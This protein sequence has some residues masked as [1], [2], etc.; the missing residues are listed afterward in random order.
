[1]LVTFVLDTSASMNQSTSSG[2]TLLDYA[3]S[4]VERF[5]KR[6]RDPSRRYQHHFMLL[7]CGRDGR[8][9]GGSKSADSTYNG[10]VRVGWDQSTNK[11]AFLRELKNLRATDL[12]DVGAALKQAFELMNQIRLQFNWDSYALGRAPWNTNVSV[13]VL[14]TDA[15]T[16][17]SADG[18]IQDALTIAPSNTVGAD[19][20]FEPYRWDQRL[21]TVALKLSATMNGVKGQP[22]V[23]ADLMALS[24][25]TGGML[26]MPTSKPAVEQSIDQIIL[27]LK[28]GAVVKFKCEAM[29]GE[30][31][32]PVARNIIA[33]FHS[34]KE[35]CWPVAE[36][37][38]LDRNTV[39]LPTREAHPTLVYSRTVENAIEAATSHMLLDTLKFPADT[40]VLETSISPTPSRG[41]RWLVYVQG[42]KG[43]GRLGDP[44]GMLRA[45]SSTPGIP[46]FNPVL[47]LLPYNFPKLFSLLVEV[48]RVYQASGQNI[49]SASGT[50]MFQAK[51]MPSSWR[52]SF[53]AYLS[54]CPL[55]YYAPLKK[56][57]RK[58]N[59]HDMVPEVQ[60]S[61]RSYQISS[62][63][64]RLREQAIA[65]SDSINKLFS[66]A[67]RNDTSSSARSSGIP[68][69]SPSASPI[70]NRDATGANQTDATLDAIA[71][72]SLQELRAAHQKSKALF[73]EKSSKHQLQISLPRVTAPK[74]DAVPLKLTPSWRAVEEDEKHR[75]P[76]DVMSDYESRLIKK[77][78]LRNP[79]AEAEPDEDTPSGLRRRQ[80]SFNLGNPYKKSSSKSN[81]YQNEAADEA[82]ALGGQSPKRQRTRKR[83]SQLK[84][85]KKH[86]KRSHRMHGSP[87]FKSSPGSPSHS[88]T[89]PVSST[90]STIPSPGRSD[91]GDSVMTDSSVGSNYSVKAEAAQMLGIPLHDGDFVED[92]KNASFVR[93]V[94]GVLAENWESWSTIIRLIKA[95]STTQQEKE[96]VVSGLRSMKGSSTAVKTYIEQAIYYSQQ[97]RQKALEQQLK[98]LL[99]EVTKAA[100]D[101]TEDC[102]PDVPKKSTSSDIEGLYDEQAQFKEDVEEDTGAV[103]QRPELAKQLPIKAVGLPLDDTTGVAGSWS[104]CMVTAFDVSLGRF[105]V[106][107]SAGKRVGSPV[108]HRGLL[109]LEKDDCEAFV[110]RIQRA[111]QRREQAEAV[112]RQSLY[113]ESMPISSDT[114]LDSQTISNILQLTLSSSSVPTDIGTS[115]L[116]EEVNADY[117]Y[118]M[119]KLI[120]ETNVDDIQSEFSDLKLPKVPAPP[121]PPQC[122]IIPVP[123]YDYNRRFLDIAT[124]KFVNLS[125][126]VN[127]LLDVRRSC[128][129]VGTQKLLLEQQ[130]T[131]ISFGGGARPQPKSISLAEFHSLHAQM[132]HTALRFMRDCWT[133]LAAKRIQQHF[134]QAQHPLYNPAEPSRQKYLEMPLRRF[135]HRVNY[136]VEDTLRVLIQQNFEGYAEFVEEMAGYDV[137]DCVRSVASL[138]EH[139][140]NIVERAAQPL[141]KYHLQFD[142]YIPLLNLDVDEY[143]KT[144][145]RVQPEGNAEGEDGEPTPILPPVELNELRRLLAYHRN[146]EETLMET[147]PSRAVNLG[148]FQ[149]DLTNIRFTLAKKH[150]DC[151]ARL[152][153][154]QVAFCFQIA[155]RIMGKFDEINQNLS[156]TPKDIESLTALQEYIT[157]LPAL[158]AP[159]QEEILQ[160]MR[161]NTLIDDFHHYV[162]DEHLRLTWQVQGWPSK[163]LAQSARFKHALEERKSK[164]AKQMES[165]QER[166]E[167]TLAALQDEIETFSR[168]DNLAFVED[169]AHHAMSVQRKLEQAQQDAM[170]FNSRETLFGQEVT[171]YDGLASAKK[172]F[173]PYHQLWSTSYNWIQSR[174]TWIQGSFIDIDAEQVEKLVDTYSTGIQKAYKFF[175][176]NGNEACSKIAE[177]VKEQIS[178]FRPYVPLIVAL[179]NPGMRLRHWEEL[180]KSLGFALEIDESFTLTNIFQLNLLERID[181]IVKVAE[182][183]GKEYQVEQALRTMKAAWETVDLQIIAYRETGTYVIKG[184]DEIQAILDEHVTMTQAMMFSTF[185]GPFEEE[186]IEWN[187]TLQLISEVLE[188]WLAVQRNWL[189]LQPIFESPDINKQLPAEG[190]RFASVDKNWRQTLASAKAKPK[191]VEFCRSQKLLE[192]FRESNHFLELVQ[193]GLSDYLEVKRS[194]FARFYFLSNDELLSILSESKDVKLVQ[195]HLK[196]CFEGIVQVTFEDDLNISAM[197]SAEGEK[198]PFSSMVD[199]KGKNVEHWMMEVEDMMKISIRD[200][201]ERAIANYTQIDR[202]LWIQKWPG[203]CVLNGSQMHWTREMEEAMDADGR[204]GVQKMMTRQLGQLADMVTLVRGNLDN[205]ARITCGALTVIDV[206]A[207][208]VTRKL[209]AQKVESKGDFLWSS[210]LKYYWADKNLWVQAVTSRRPYGYEYLGNS[211][212]LVITPLTDKCYL[213]LMGALQMILGGAPAG[214]AG[215]GKT[216]TTKDLAKALAKQCVVFNCSDGLDY[217]AMGKFFK[218]LASCGAWA[219]FDEFNRI[220]IEV[221]SVVG[222]QVVTLQ[223]GIRRGDTRIIFEG[224]D[225]KLSDQFGVFITMNP[226]YAGRSELPDSLAALFRPVAMMVPD[227]ALIGEIMFFAYGFS[228]ARAL[229]AKMVTTFKLCSEQLSSQFHYDYGMRAVK[230]VITAA[231]NLKRDDPDMDEDVL[232]LRALQDVNLP[233]FLAHDIPLFNG[234]ISDLFP[235]KCRPNLDLGAL[236]SVIKLQ[237]HRLNLQPVPY[238]L[239]K[240]IQLYETIVVRHGLMVVGATGGGK[241]CNIAVLAD[242][243]TELK[244]RGE[245]GFAFEKV[246][247]YQLN[248]KSITMGQL[249]GEFDP[250]THEWQDGILSTLYRAAASDTKPDRKWVIFDGPVDAIWIENMNTVLDDNKKLCLNSGEMLQMSKQMTMMFEVEDLSV[251]SPATVSRTGMVYME[252]S[253]L[254]LG[255]LVDSW[256]EH[257]PKPV[258]QFGHIFMRLF[259]VYLYASVT[260][261][262]SFLGEL[263]PTMDNNLA[264]SL[265]NILDCTLDPFREKPADGTGEP[266]PAS[267]TPNA[268]FQDDI[269]PLFIFALIWSVGASTND[270]GRVRFDSFLRSELVANNCK[271]PLPPTGLVYDYC[272]QL[273]SHKWV[274]WM[275]TVSPYKVPANSSFAEIV[276]PTADSVR[277]NFLLEELMSAGKHVLMVGGTGTGKTVNITRYLQSLPTDVYIPIPISFSAQTSANQTQD[278]LDAKM[279]KRRKGVYGP[280]A[281]K[282]YII[283]VDDLNMPKREKYFAQ[284][285]LEL[286]RQWFDQGGWYD[287]KLL[288]F[289]SIIDILFVASMGPPGGG[290]NPITPRLVRH[291]NVVGY[292]ELGDDSKTIIFSTILGNF[293]GSGF[294]AEIARLTE[295]VVKASIS[296]YN[297]ICR[298]LLPTPAKS[299][300]TFNLRDLAKVFQGVL[301]GDSRRIS[302]TDSLIRLWVHEC[303]RVYEDRMVSTQDHDWF[304]E[305]MRSSV[306]KFFEREYDQVVTNEHLIYGDYLVPGADPKIYEEIVHVDKVLNIMDEYLLDYNAESK[307]PMSLVLF[308]DAV[309]HVSR[310]SRIIRQPMGNALLLGVGGSGRQSLTKL[311]TF[312]AGYKCFQVE[313]VKGYGLTEWRDD[314]KKCLLLAGV[315]DIP[316][317]FLFSDVQVVNETMLEDLNGVLNAGNVPNLYGPEDLDQIVTACRVDCQKRQLPPTKTNIFQQ[318]INRV[319]RNIHLVICMSPLGGLFRDRLRMFP[320]LVNCSTIDWFSEWPAEALNSVASAILSDGNLALGDKLP[321]LVEAFKVV[322]QSVE[323]ASKQFYNTLR[324]Y[325][326]VTPTSYLELLSAF[327]SV[328]VAKR[329]EVNM[330]RSRLQNGVDK[331]SETKAIVATM[332]TELVE[333]QPVL[334]ATQLEVEQM[335]VQIAKDSAEAD[336]TKATVEKEEA[337]ASIKASATKEIADSAQRDLDAALPALESALE[338]LNRLKKADIDE[339]KALKTPPAGVK[340]TM[341]V[342]CILFGQ[343][344]VSKPDPDRPGK[345]INDYWE[346]AQKV[347]LSNA[348]KFLENLLGFDKDNIPDAIITKVTPSMEDPNFTPEAIEKSSK[349]CTAIC[350]WARAMYTYHFVAKAVEPKKQALAQAQKELDET[351]A[352]LRSAQ[353]N[354][355][356]VSDRLAEL[357]QS[358][359]GAV[360]KK[361]ELARKVVQCQVQLQNAERLIGGL[362][363]EE[364]RWKETV[365]Q[366]TLDYSNLTGDVLVSAGTISYLGAFTA[367][368]REQLVASWHEALVKHKVPHSPGC[369]LIRTL[370]DPVKLRAWQIAGLPTDTVST[371]NGIIMGRARRWPLLIDPQGQ[372]NRFIKNLGRDKK[373]CENGMDVV[374]QSDRGFL[375]ALENGLRFGKWVLLENV[376]EELDAALEPVLLQQKFKQG[377]QDMIRLGENVIPYNDSFRFFLTTKLANPH[378]A[379][380][381]CVKVSLLN[382]TITMKGLEEQL[383]GV[384][385]LKELPELAAKKNELV[386]SNAEGKRQLYEIE[387]QILY[388]LSHSEGNILDDTNLIE[389]LASAKETSA[390]VMA[391]MREA[392]ETEREIDARSDG[393]RPVAFRAALLFF[394]IADLALVDP[395]YQYSLTWFTGLFIRGILAAK[396]SAQLETRL[397]NLNDYFTYSVY[398]NICRSLFEKHKLLFSFLLTIKIMQGNNEVDA[399]EWRFL[400]SGIGTGAPVEAENPAARWL[401]AYAWQQICAL[402]SFPAFKGL[403]TEFANHVAVFRAIFDSTDPENQPLPGELL[404]KLDEFQR[405]CILRVLRPDKMM[406]GIQN[407]VCAK[408]GK[409]FIEPPPFDLANTFEDA[410]PTTPLIFVLSQGSDPAKDLHGFA[411]STGME[412][413]LKSI[414]LGQGQGTLAAR[415]IEG[416]T[417]RGEWVLLQNCHLALSWMP[418]LERICEELDPTKLHEDFRLWLTSMPTPAFPASVLQDGVK[419]TK[420]APKGL[421]ANLK[422]TYYKLDEMR[423]GATRKPDVFRKLL[424]GLCFYHAIVCERKRFGALGWNIPYQFNETDLDISVAQLEMFLDTYN[425]VPF[426]V[427][428]VMTSTINYGGRITDDKDMRTSDVILMTFFKEAILQKGYT[429]SKSGI[430]YSLDCDPRN[431][432]DGYVN[433]INLLPINPEPEVF[434]MHENANIT[435]A[436]AETYEAFDLLL[437]LQPRVSSGGGK[438]REEIIADAAQAIASQLPPQYDLEHVQATY[439]V[440]YD[441]SMNTVLAQEVERFNKLLAVMR[442]TLHLVQQGL[443]GLVVMSAELEAMGASLYD[444][445]VP[446]VWEAKAYP[447]L[448]PLGAWV[449]DLLERLT[450]ISNWIAHG[451]PAVFWISGFFFPQG[452]MT[453]T[454]QNHAR[455]YKLP[456]DSLSFQFIMKTESVE[457]LTARP[458]DGCYTYGLFLEGAR[459][460]SEMKALD[461][462]LPRELFAKMP[463]IHLLPQPNREAPQR[464]IYRCPVYKILT[465]TGTLSTTGHSTNFVMWLEIP[466]SKPTIFR[467]SLVSE[468]NA[469]VLFADQEYWIKAGVACFCSLR[470]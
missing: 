375:R 21:F 423:L 278:M 94:Y 195:P 8:S 102:A 230:T 398:K 27:K 226:G 333:L 262:R 119:N 52:E 117:M 393:Y 194:A 225:I 283:Y 424:F 338:C 6:V 145:I 14:L 122:G 432:Y 3:K 144:I 151:F 297:T 466:A 20:T 372:A 408:L 29:E 430:Y 281:G 228:D 335:M 301:M 185:K 146:E 39:A 352:I 176:N 71:S 173:E 242:A 264:Q 284:P 156:S 213:T 140:G 235:G 239:T 178:V 386:L 332:Q 131:E 321:A 38:W 454:I 198:V 422:N 414:A 49:N 391:K 22:T 112:L 435:S 165:E 400:L 469:Q 79:L 259:D 273:S 4:A 337:A 465:R 376:G 163:V 397:T 455:R 174:K 266:Q 392:E 382:F 106:S 245:S 339:V 436:Q 304:R 256:V 147:I 419:M 89:S 285:P 401:E 345:K 66:R 172:T 347:V 191:C 458:V 137:E 342:V 306:K 120:F 431:A 103:D 409:E 109:C 58:Y 328:L 381:V 205:M 329:E 18:L 148:L 371:Q 50:W 319:R 138:K 124:D 132:S 302:E 158:L 348:N 265:M 153:E 37:F 448:K 253:T 217:I 33:P 90:S 199:P 2:M 426:D 45:P 121:P 207:R 186:I 410:S 100:Q 141:L 314:V 220:D 208:D 105:I 384:V 437:S 396:P 324:R 412:S 143:L 399:G 379:P 287:R 111:V 91:S 421:R 222:Q 261:I 317:V 74:D 407:L 370:Q 35:F 274:P 192:R 334:A 82:A 416:A 32:F 355:Q 70:S 461:D 164:F 157:G 404:S 25:A 243:L 175:S 161:D 326:Y 7:S 221:L 425:H 350:M 418:E 263:V 440:C 276:V 358:Y 269:E 252:P 193:K 307:S 77:E 453:G 48:A 26:Y 305:L 429:F 206:H 93:Q 155:T 84:R 445:K 73:F 189:Y 224:S 127:A 439:P 181:D 15:T 288:V 5:V 260:F 282:K 34:G 123:A 202:S 12:S 190:K 9:K 28:A 16:L 210:Q 46:T 69:S 434:G 92:E 107:W 254:G 280:P 452:F 216:E 405:L 271:P 361:E 388:L 359:N 231:G 249:Y 211:F 19:L 171:S 362:G 215:T 57:L 277:N 450:F 344:P 63:L 318:Y 360:A 367:E 309:E 343:K 443:K 433:Y 61:G 366:L 88:P 346:V 75:Q 30:A 303:K 219:C 395:M 296:V 83:S 223:L 322:H 209:V 179:R 11:E 214:P 257:L 177:T 290:R 238:F 308:M 464:G 87:S 232:L 294:P 98:Q 65:E 341:E 349:A 200:I 212:R 116:L 354:L 227:Y 459:W 270:A 457:Q 258:A 188:E 353:A 1:M 246:I 203:M 170:L 357:E 442:S 365:A 229:G 251:A 43:D 411:V 289:R 336:V 182:A 136:M 310:I 168:Y 237:T 139:V 51:A 54:G 363:G 96:F 13:C 159:M 470:Y 167:K 420:E 97:F 247:K 78:A 236:I 413:K 101:K 312:M 60:D 267:K 160:M 41:Q 55:Y 300:Y 126:A 130:P 315:K 104:S 377:G 47:V 62:F 244:R 31:D 325:F 40:Y 390:V 129:D 451:I 154:A 113:V 374:K 68:E 17:S 444:Q 72:M 298:E 42:S 24:E 378:Y 23:P 234:I 389:T 463:V 162:S 114:Q 327:K 385:V 368:F 36:A 460:N 95:R 201:M 166:F 279:E 125:F 275:S 149:V 218:G 446:A 250:N 128:V 356:Q 291:F 320:S 184:V 330:M 272:Y 295:N 406:P 152:L 99:D 150:R 417:T 402:A 427:L 53:S 364:A 299:H 438:S 64:N 373:L 316:V 76:I 387:N 115:E 293:L 449:K 441:E 311:A 183:A 187:S 286:V 56:A 134:S 108:M 59:L 255:P 204:E 133:R 369:D 197:I 241:S 462:P 233:K 380:E 383:L 403:E 268:Q 248:P 180:S 331:L 351:L 85:D 169:V 340:L 323:E 447:S 313:I 81:V 142:P 467:N 118:T 415:L 394:C 44:I 67:S 10:R 80:L 86:S 428:Q 292:A 456:I 240:C 110:Q 135:L 196:K 468:T